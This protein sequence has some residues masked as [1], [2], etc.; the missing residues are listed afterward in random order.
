[1]AVLEMLPKTTGLTKAIWMTDLTATDLTSA[2]DLSKGSVFE[3]FQDAANQF[4]DRPF[5]HIPAEAAKAY[6]GPLSTSPTAKLW[7]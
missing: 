6:G 3:I 2:L 7:R 5:L 1:M 4:A